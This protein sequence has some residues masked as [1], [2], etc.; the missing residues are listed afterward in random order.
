M[1]GRVVA[2]VVAAGRS[3]RMGKT[4]KLW[5][6]LPSR[7]GREEPLIAHTLTAFQ[8]SHN[9][10][11]GILV[12]AES[13]LAQAGNM[14]EE[15]GFNK[16]S[17]VAGGERRQDSVRAGLQAAQ[18]CEW[19]IIHDGARPLVTA[20]L[21]EESL[22]IAQ[23]TGASCCAIPIADTVKEVESGSVVRTVD[24]SHLWLAQTPQTFRYE[25]LSEAHNHVSTDVTDDASL[26]ESSGVEVRLCK[27]SRQNI[28]VTTLEDL[29]FVAALLS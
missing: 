14:I 12:A 6:P 19:V 23:E 11:C 9:V 26:I 24:R 2:I 18:D 20:D 16:F 1:H 17:V 13:K 28:K 4:D 15:H 25:L 29:K 10:N 8:K 7:N 21:I 5:A 3:E 27:G 22:R